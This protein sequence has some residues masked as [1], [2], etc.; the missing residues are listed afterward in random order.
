MKNN[1]DVYTVLVCQIK[2]LCDK[3]SHDSIVAMWNI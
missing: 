1:V 3:F 2:M